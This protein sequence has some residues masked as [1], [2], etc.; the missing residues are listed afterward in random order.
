[1]ICN[2]FDLNVRPGSEGSGKN[3]SVV[4]THAL[5][6][7]AIIM[8]KN[9]SVIVTHAL[10]NGAIIMLKNGSV[11]VTHALHNGALIIIK[12]LNKKKIDE[13]KSQK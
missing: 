5:H 4:V 12:I 8:L 6:N 11:I 13:I 2:Q 1:M 10:H 3:G 7:G 9:G